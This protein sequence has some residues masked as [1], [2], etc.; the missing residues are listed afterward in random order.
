MKLKKRKKWSQRKK[1]TL[2]WSQAWCKRREYSTLRC[3]LFFLLLYVDVHFCDIF[4]QG[5]QFNHRSM[6]VQ[7]RWWWALS[8]AFCTNTQ[9]ASI[10]LR[11]FSFVEGHPMST[12]E[13]VILYYFFFVV[14]SKICHWTLNC[15]SSSCFFFD[16]YKFLWWLMK[17][18]LNLFEMR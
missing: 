4:S 8:A 9:T 13:V 5:K 10:D 6:C 12:F 16:I 17:I 2:P 7:Q 18:F 14:F 3:A 15:S 1:R 11:I